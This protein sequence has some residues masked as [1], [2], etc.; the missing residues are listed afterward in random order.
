MSLPTRPLSPCALMGKTSLWPVTTIWNATECSRALGII[1][2]RVLRN[3]FFRLFSSRVVEIFSSHKRVITLICNFLL[4]REV[5]QQHTSSA[6]LPHVLWEQSVCGRRW[7]PA[8]HCACILRC[9]VGGRGSPV[10][11][12]NLGMKFVHKVES[13]ILIKDVSCIQMPVRLERTSKP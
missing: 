7:P 5:F 13:S 8:Q 1:R 2:R 10:L 6:T 4:R 11:R 3:A 12:F 9:A